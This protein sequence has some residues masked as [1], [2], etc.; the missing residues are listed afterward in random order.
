MKTNRSILVVHVAALLACSCGRGSNGTVVHHD[1]SNGQTKSQIA[2]TEAMLN[3]LIST[4]MTKAEITNRL[5]S[6]QQ[7]MEVVGGAVA[8][9]YFF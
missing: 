4:G 7:S 3:S 6:P 5:G 9:D 2:I 1:V 8:F